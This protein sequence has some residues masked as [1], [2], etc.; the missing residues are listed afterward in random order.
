ML[1]VLAVIG[2]VDSRVCI[3]CT[4]N[5]PDFGRGTVTRLSASGKINMLFDNG[6]TKSCLITAV[7]KVTS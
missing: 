4:V 7:T 3:G 2:G 1:A 6:S 5:H